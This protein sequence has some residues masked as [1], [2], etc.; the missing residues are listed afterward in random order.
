MSDCIEFDELKRIEEIKYI[1][2][3]LKTRKNSIRELLKQIDSCKA[4][5]K[6]CEE[7]LNQLNKI[8]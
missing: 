5:I 4:D 3:I 2:S 7:K 6:F 1:N 8:E